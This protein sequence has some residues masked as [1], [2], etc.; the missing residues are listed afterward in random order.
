MI[1]T[2]CIGPGH[3]SVDGIGD[4]GRS[5]RRR[6]PSCREQRR[7]V[8]HIGEIGTG[9][10]RRT[11]GHQIERHIR[12]ERFAA[13][14]HQKYLNTTLS[15]GTVHDDVAVE[16]PGT[17]QR[18]AE[19]V[20]SVGGRELRAATQGSRRVAPRQ[21][22]RGHLAGIDARQQLVVAQGRTVVASTQGEVRD[23]RH[24]QCGGDPDRSGAQALHRVATIFQPRS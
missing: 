16:A 21:L 18:R 3:H 2:L 6:A 8:E 4:V 17:K 24:E 19:D 5:D 14:L 13:R 9:E 1:D 15:V 20:G 23:R 22:D 11:A 7:F 12:V 10:A